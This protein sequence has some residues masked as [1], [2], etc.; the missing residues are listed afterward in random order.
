M[1]NSDENVYIRRC[2][3]CDHVMEAEERSILECA[4]CGKHFAPFFYFDDRLSPI[5]GDNTLKAPLLEGEYRPIE[6]L[7]VYWQNF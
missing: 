3:V 5:L 2:H 4:K 1:A 7:T 6:G